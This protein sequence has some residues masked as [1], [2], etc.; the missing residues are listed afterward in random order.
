MFGHLF[1]HL[2]CA[3]KV[4]AYAV[5]ALKVVLLELVSQAT[6]P[7]GIHPHIPSTGQDHQVWSF[8]VQVG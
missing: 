3:W 4:Q 7:E 1:W 2:V 8:T 6:S 5:A